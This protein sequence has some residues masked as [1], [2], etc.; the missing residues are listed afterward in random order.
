M[1][2]SIE[3]C[4]RT[5]DIEEVAKVPAQ[6]SA[7]SA[8]RGCRFNGIEGSKGVAVHR[9][10]CLRGDCRGPKKKILFCDDFTKDKCG[11]KEKSTKE[12]S[13]Y[14]VRIGWGRGYPIKQT[15]VIISK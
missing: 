4:P 14:D 7:W 8:V 3:S 2:T 5:V 13:T 9:R 11:G 15:I 1:L 6:W 12:Q 10:R